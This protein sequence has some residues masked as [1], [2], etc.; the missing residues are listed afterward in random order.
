M[1]GRKRRIDSASTVIESHLSVWRICEDEH[2]EKA[3]YCCESAHSSCV[4]EKNP[5][6]DLRQH[7][8][9]LIRP[10]ASRALLRCLEKISLSVLKWIVNI[11]RKQTRS[12]EKISYPQNI[13]GDC[14]FLHKLSDC[15]HLE[16]G[17][18]VP[19]V[20]RLIIHI[21]K[22]GDLQWR[23]YYAL[24]IK[25]RGICESVTFSLKR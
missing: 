9:C 13:F 22:L 25:K 5:R 24:D 1:D 4:I 12:I 11:S 10:Q 21:T 20:C 23:G 6:V 15:L 17:R 16:S 14:I 7:I 3:Y 19:N 18:A 2:V 8:R